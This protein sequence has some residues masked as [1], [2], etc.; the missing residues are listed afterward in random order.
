MIKAALEHLPSRT[1]PSLLLSLVVPLAGCAVDVLEADEAAPAELA[2]GLSTACPNTCVDSQV[3]IGCDD[4]EPVSASVDVATTAPWSFT[5]RFDGGTKCS[6]ALIGDRFVLTAAHCMLGQ[7]GA[8]L[9]FAL[10]QEVQA[11][12]GRP[13]GTHAVRRVYVPTAFVINDGEANRALDYAVAELWNPIPGATPANYEYINW[14]T[15]QGYPARSVGYPATPPDGGFLGRPFST[16]GKNWQSTQPFAWLGG[17]ESGL[18]YSALDASGNQS[19]SPVYVIE[20]DG[21]RTVTGVLIG[22]PQEAC[23]D[24]ENWVARLTPGAVAHIQNAMTP[25]VIDFFWTRTNI[26]FSPDAGP[27][28]TWP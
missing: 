12:T 8:Q 10:A 26:P 7:G 23:Q 13:Y 20:P 24:G 6:G 2:S 18:L 11:F 19:G 4:R 5:G 9:G 3:I 27:G 16:G 14:A 1:L 22:S 28:Q 17:G 21:T 25:H 15:L